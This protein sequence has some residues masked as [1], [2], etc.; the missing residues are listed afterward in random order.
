MFTVYSLPFNRIL[1]TLDN[2]SHKFN[3]NVNVDV[4]K[5]NF[6]ININLDNFLTLTFFITNGVL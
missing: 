1:N 5:F 4:D 2:V 6:D 3:L